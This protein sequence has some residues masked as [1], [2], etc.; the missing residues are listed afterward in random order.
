M[1]SVECKKARAVTSFVRLSLQHFSKHSATDK[2]NDRLFL[3][4]NP[5]L[6]PDSTQIIHHQTSVTFSTPE[7]FSFAQVRRRRVWGREWH[8]LVNWLLRTLVH[9][10]LHERNPARAIRLIMTLSDH[11]FRHVVCQ[12]VYHYELASVNQL[13]TSGQDREENKDEVWQGHLHYCWLNFVLSYLTLA[14]K[15]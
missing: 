11:L 5:R 6:S 9:H 10:Y 13:H 1:D 3:K 8:R 14:M 15:T 7:L 2:L 12:S 4:L